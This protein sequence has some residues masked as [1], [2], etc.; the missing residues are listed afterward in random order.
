MSQVP[1]S[2]ARPVEETLPALEA[3]LEAL[4][5]AAMAVGREEDS[6][7]LQKARKARGVFNSALDTLRRTERRAGRD[8]ACSAIR[9]AMKLE[10]RSLNARGPSAS[11]V[12]YERCITDEVG[13]LRAATW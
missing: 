1:K 3:A 4:L 2:Q 6:Q 5:R 8:G 13:K 9:S 12:D 7:A 10:S 11:M